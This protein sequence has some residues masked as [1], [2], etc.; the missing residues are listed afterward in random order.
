MALVHPTAVMVGM[1]RLGGHGCREERD[2]QCWNSAGAENE[3][4]NL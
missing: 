2:V 3:C 1:L 4:D